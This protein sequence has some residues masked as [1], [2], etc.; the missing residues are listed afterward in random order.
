MF[1]Y[2]L[3]D[4][5]FKKIGNCYP[6]S[7]CAGGTGKESA[8]YLINWYFAWGGS[9]NAQYGWSWRIGDGASHFGYQNPLAAYALANDAA[10]KPKGATAVDDW[11]KSLQRQLELYEYLQTSTGPFAGGVTNSWKG[12]YDTPDSDLLNDTF[13]GM[14]YDWEPVSIPDTPMISKAIILVCLGL[15]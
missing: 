2:S 15:P 1:R 11:S 8:H 3:F 13:Y 10:L 12:H 5:Y 4:K 9:Y 6:A 14:F 7:G